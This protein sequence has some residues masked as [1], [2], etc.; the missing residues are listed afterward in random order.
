MTSAHEKFLGLLKDD[1][2]K[3]DLAELEFGI[4]RILNYRRREIEAFLDRELPLKIGSRSA[5]IWR[6]RGSET[7]PRYFRRSTGMNASD[8]IM[9]SLKALGWR[10]SWAR[11]FGITPPTTIRPRLQ[12]STST[13]SAMAQA[14][15]RERSRERAPSPMRKRHLSASDRS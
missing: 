3:L 5:C 7:T 2:L 10:T 11:S 15:K 8:S 6:T 1:I 12:R 9:P 13:S 14:R 4:Y